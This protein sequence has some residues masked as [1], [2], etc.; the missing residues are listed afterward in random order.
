MM[1][2]PSKQTFFHQKTHEGKMGQLHKGI[3]ATSKDGKMS[4]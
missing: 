3:D 2:N 1:P 4:K